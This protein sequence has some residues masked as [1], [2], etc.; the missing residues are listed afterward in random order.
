MSTELRHLRVVIAAADGESFS[1]AAK[2]LNID[3]SVVSR[4]VRDLELSIGIRIFERLPRGLRLTTAGADYV[5]SARDILA[6]VDRASQAASLAAAGCTGLL[7]IGFVWS[8]SS[9]PVVGLLRSLRAAYPGIAVRNVEDGNESL[10]KRLEADELDVVLV[11]TGPPPFT[12]LP[13]IHGLSTLPLWLEPL[14]TVVPS[15]FDGDHVEWS[16]LAARQLL[17]QTRDDWQ[18]FV[19]YVERLGGPTLNFA[20]QDVSREGIIGLVAAGLGWAIAPASVAPKGFPGVRTVPIT[21]EGAVLQVQAIWKSHVENP[22]F[23]RFLE[24]ARLTFN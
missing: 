18:R 3:V 24:L 1:A 22:A 19:T 16:D 8:F 17:C 5:A 9:E 15:V 12:R 11:A 4:I 7:A 10:V 23:N 20:V 14:V 2:R 13:D 21:S 6:R